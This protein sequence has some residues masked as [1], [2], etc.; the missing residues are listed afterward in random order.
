MS[1]RFALERYRGE[2]LAFLTQHGKE[3]LLAPVLDQALGCTVARVAGFDTDTLGTFTRDIPREGT[4]LEAARRKAQLAIELSG[5]RLG[6][7][8]EGAFGP[9]PY[10]GFLPWNAEVLVLVDAI[11]GLEVIGSAQAPAAS[12]HAVVTDEGALQAF[13]AKA[14]FPAQRLVLR[15]DHEDHP[16]LW[17]GLGND[18]ELRAAF[19]AAQ[20]LSSGGKVFV[21]PDFRAHF[22]PARQAVITAAGEDL[23]RRLRLACPGCGRPGF[24]M[25]ELRPGLPCAACGAPTREPLAEIHACAGCGMRHERA[26]ARAVA[27]PG[28]CEACNP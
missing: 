2:R 19:R 14:G 20:T 26:A 24:S 9:D 10:T 16:R 15:P 22:N 21:E 4:Q 27:D 17:K 25:V 3:A 18:A 1:T 12:S 5:A 7:G 28:R 6:L 13:A 8:S 23:L 11:H